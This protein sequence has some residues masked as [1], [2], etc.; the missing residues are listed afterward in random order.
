[1][2]PG[3]RYAR[4]L[5]Q[6]RRLEPEGTDTWNPLG[7]ERE[8]VHRL[9]LYE[10]IARALRCVP[11][12]AAELRLLDVG[13]GTGRSTRVYLDFGLDPAKLRG[14]DLRPGAIELARA[15]NPAVG[16]EAFDGER[17]PAEDGSV[18]WL[19]LCTVL[20]SVPH[21]GREH[22]VEEAARVLAPGGVVFCWDKDA[23]HDFAGG[24]ALKPK[25]L[26]AG[27]QVLYEEHVCVHGR[28]ERLLPGGVLGRALGPVL[29]RLGPGAT[30]RALLLGR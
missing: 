27:W 26:F 7:S 3:S 20:S 8:L 6:Y 15:C 9:A 17:L 14:V 24:G 11:G 21:P 1:M 22:L 19:A 2:S 12:E 28:I 23:V 5:E 10:Q 29:R 4:V 13:C 30:H 18:D 16:F 25:Q